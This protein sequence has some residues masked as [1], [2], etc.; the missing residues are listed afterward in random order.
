[1][2]VKHLLA[3]H[4]QNNIQQTKK[5]LDDWYLEKKK[6]YM[7]FAS[8]YPMNGEVRLQDAKIESM[9][10]WCKEAEITH[11]PTIFFNSKKLV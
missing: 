3:I 8:K 11:T 2:V 7:S 10:K 9:T 1:M 6:D 5:A 4:A